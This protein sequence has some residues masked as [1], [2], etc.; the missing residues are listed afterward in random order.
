MG[1]AMTAI[2]IKKEMLTR[3]KEELV[4]IICKLGKS[5][6]EANDLLN[7]LLGNDSI[8]E[9]ALEDAKKKIRNQFFPK[10]G[11]G[12]LNLATAKS[13]ITAFKKICDDPEK[14]IDLQLFYVE[15]GV[16]F[17]NEYGDI[18]ESFYSSMERM[19]ETAIKSLIKTK[20]T[21]LTEKLMPRLKK[22]VNDVSGI[23]WGFYDDLYDS[24]SLLEDP[25]K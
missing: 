23:G 19:Y 16:E 11:L 12:R 20:N 4:E 10:R 17:T 13:A 7:L 18:N 1:K 3:S 8:L 14:V 9:D 24:F 15:C 6:K 22:I 2:Q 21:S 5:S 25:D